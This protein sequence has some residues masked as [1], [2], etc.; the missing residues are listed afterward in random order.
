MELERETLALWQRR[1]AVRVRAA[2]RS[3]KRLVLGTCD[4]QQLVYT[5]SLYRTV[6]KDTAKRA[7]TTHRMSCNA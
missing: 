7:C 2:K 5:F 4:E 1:P 6:L 3:R